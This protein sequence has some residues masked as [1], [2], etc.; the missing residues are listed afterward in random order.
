MLW[1]LGGLPASRAFPIRIPGPL[2]TGKMTHQSSVCRDS[3]TGWWGS[4][5]VCAPRP[6]PSSLLHLVCLGPS[7]IPPAS[8]HTRQSALG[9][10]ACGLLWG[11]GLYECLCESQR[12]QGEVRER[13]GPE[14]QA[15]CM[16]MPVLDTSKR[17]AA[18]LP[19]AWNISWLLLL[20]C[21][22]SSVMLN[23]K[24]RPLGWGRVGL[25]GEGQSCWTG[26]FK[27]QPSCWLQTW[28]PHG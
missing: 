16:E 23:K 6:L 26:V 27:D 7:H 2:E 12:D 19:Q 24:L 15:L 25:V 1:T 4:T 5:R 11:L 10:P 9:H 20:F 28:R 21:P 8:F 17:E 14:L 22:F 18:R 3:A 13:P